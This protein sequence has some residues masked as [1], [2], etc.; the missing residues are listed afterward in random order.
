MT[1]ADLDPARPAAVVQRDGD[2]RFAAAQVDAGDRE[3]LVA[4]LRETEA[5]PSS[6]RPTLASTRRSS[7]PPSN[8]DAPT[9]T[10]R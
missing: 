2:E 6:T 9:S 4:L 3:A 10:W 7:T 1:F 8:T 5:R